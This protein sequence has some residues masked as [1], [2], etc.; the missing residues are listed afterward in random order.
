MALT[1]KFVACRTNWP[2]FVIYCPSHGATSWDFTRLNLSNIYS[3]LTG[4]ERILHILSK[5]FYDF[6]WLIIHW[7]NLI[8]CHPITRESTTA[9]FSKDLAV[10][11]VHNKVMGWLR[12]WIY[13]AKCLWIHYMFYSPCNYIFTF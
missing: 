13:K 4:F 2:H 1:Q 3:F 8:K 6:Q 5:F 12:L 10:R 7:R 9:Y 11:I